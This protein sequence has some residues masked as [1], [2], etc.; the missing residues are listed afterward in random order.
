MGTK[1]KKIHLPEEVQY[2]L[3]T[4]SST[5]PW[6]QSRVSKGEILNNP[7]EVG[8]GLIFNDFYKGWHT[9][10]IIDIELG[11]GNTLIFTTEN[12]IYK[13]EETDYFILK[14]ELEGAKPRPASKNR[15]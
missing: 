8:K 1:V 15:K 2:K 10:P 14:R 9:T 13:L 3:T 6:S 12:S 4:L 7:L 11:E 5:N